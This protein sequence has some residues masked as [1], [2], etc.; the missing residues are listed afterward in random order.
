[1]VS[2]CLHLQVA[3]APWDREGAFLRWVQV[4][5][6]PRALT[7]G[8]LCQFQS[9]QDVEAEETP[10]LERRTWQGVRASVKGSLSALHLPHE[11]PGDFLLSLSTF[12][13]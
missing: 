1:M 5:N 9:Q 4:C 11:E 8:T 13:S 6:C 7:T 10:R 3:G 12:T 2:P